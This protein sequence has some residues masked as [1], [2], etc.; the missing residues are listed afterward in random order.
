MASG[1]NSTFRQVGIATGIAALGAIFQHVVAQNLIEGA[2][3]RLPRGV[4]GTEAADF[5]SFGGFRAGP[6]R[7]ADPARPS[8]RSS[9]GSTT[10]CSTPAIVA[11]VG[12]I[13]A[14][15]LTRPADFVAHG[16]RAAPPN[17]SPPSRERC[18]RD[19]AHA[20]RARRGGRQPLRRH[21]RRR[22][23]RPAADALDGD[24]RGPAAHRAPLPPAR[25][26][27]RASARAGAAR[28]AAGRAGDLLRPAPRLLGRRAPAA[29]RAPDLPRRLRRDRVRRPRAR[30]RA[31]DRG[32]RAEGDPRRERGRR[33]A[34]GAGRRLVPGRHPRAARAGGRPDAAGEPRSRS[35]RAR[36][37]SPRCRSSRRCARSRRSR[38]AGASRSSTACSAAR[39]RRWSSAATRRSASTST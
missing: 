21:A 5:V 29:G 26:H 36:S 3:G 20:G 14:A 23:R 13:L 28:P 39:R 8:S 32:R 2:H 37:T 4:S 25:G 10:S 34:A 22:P 30:A 1:I 15:V 19:P 38:R 27:D 31:L 7:G 12:A 6:Q 18:A 24:R 35:W 17:L 11:F 16:A 9:T 33:R